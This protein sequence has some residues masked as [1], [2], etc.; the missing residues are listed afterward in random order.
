MFSL[1]YVPTVTFIYDYWENHCF[2]YTEPF[3]QS[4]ISVVLL[5][6]VIAFLPRGKCL[7]ISWLHSSSS[8]ISFCLF[9]IFMGFSKQE[10]WS[11]LPFP[12]PVDYILSELFNMTHPCRVT[13]HSMAHS[14]IELTKLLCHDKAMI[15]VREE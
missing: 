1:L 5:R 10:Y 14:F 4:D 3:C 2:D 13:L 11:G 9:I 6:F 8:V 12:S 7:L 15:H